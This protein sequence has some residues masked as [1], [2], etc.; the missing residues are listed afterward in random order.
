[1]DLSIK[2]SRKWVEYNKPPHALNNAIRNRRIQDKRKRKI[3]K[4]LKK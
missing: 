4:I 3:N 2:I 1:M